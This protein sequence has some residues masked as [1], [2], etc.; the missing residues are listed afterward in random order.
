MVNKVAGDAEAEPGTQ[1]PF[2]Q[3][4]LLNDS[5][6]FKVIP[7]PKARKW[8]DRFFIQQPYKC[9]PLT[10]ANQYGWV[11]LNPQSFSFEWDG[12]IHHSSLAFFDGPPYAHSLFGHGTISFN[13]DFIFRTSPGYNLWYHGLPNHF[14]DGLH[15]LE[16][17]VE[18][19]WLPFVTTVSWQITR[20]GHRITLEEGAPICCVTPVRRWDIDKFQTGVCPIKELPDF[21]RSYKIF[22]EQRT[23][24]SERYKRGEVDRRNWQKF[25]HKGVLPDGKLAP[26]DHQTKITLNP[27][28]V[29]DEPK[30]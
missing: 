23:D 13:L 10:L 5:T 29:F 7:A 14:I 22:R 24:F 16:G 6:Q 3:I 17:I 30:E 28:T 15:P 25:Y 27:F 12:G 19:D 8:M 2:L 11:V 9:L 1:T 26:P 4:V 18:S 21:E 20:P